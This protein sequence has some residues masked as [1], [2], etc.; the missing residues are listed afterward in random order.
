MKISNH[1]SKAKSIESGH[2]DFY[3]SVRD[4]IRSLMTISQLVALAILVTWMVG[5]SA[6][7][8]R[9]LIV[10][11]EASPNPIEM[12]CSFSASGVDIHKIP[13]RRG[14]GLVG[15]MK[16][17]NDLVGLGYSKRTTVSNGITYAVLEKRVKAFLKLGIH[18]KLK[19]E[20]NPYR[21]SVH[22]VDAKIQPPQLKTVPA[23]DSHFSQATRQEIKTR[24]DARTTQGLAEMRAALKKIETYQ[25]RFNSDQTKQITSAVIGHIDDGVTV[26]YCNKTRTLKIRVSWSRQINKGLGAP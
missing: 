6:Q 20:A 13:I 26:D 21:A 10:K 25:V 18:V 4:K 16:R 11:G 15:N 17:V 8:K 24:L 1:I 14:N 2:I 7:A 22:I 9:V 12:T 23:D 3:D 19:V 5:S